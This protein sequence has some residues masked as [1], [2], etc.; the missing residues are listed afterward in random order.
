MSIREKEEWKE[1][2]EHDY[3]VVDEIE[4]FV[5]RPLLERGL[6]A[7]PDVIETECISLLVRP[8]L[9][10][11]HHPSRIPLEENNDVSDF[12]QFG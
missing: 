5:V 2:C 7:V 8:I 3:G 4:S 6:E 10:F 11:C 9:F 12:L 1:Y